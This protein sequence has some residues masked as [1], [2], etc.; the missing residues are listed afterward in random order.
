MSDPPLISQVLFLIPKNPPPTL[1]ATFSRAFREFVSACLQRDPL[2]RPTAKEL[3]KHRFV[4]SAKRTSSLVE[5]IERLQKWKKEGGERED[6]GD[7]SGSSDGEYVYALASS[8]DRRSVPPGNDDLWDF[9]TVRNVHARPGTLKKTQAA[10][11]SGQA[12]PFPPPPMVSTHPP[13]PA[14]VTSRDYADVYADSSAAF[15]TVRGSASVTQATAALPRSTT[16]KSLA[17]VDSGH[18]AL[19]DPSFEYYREHNGAGSNGAV[20]EDEESGSIL[21]T[22]LLP[23]LDSVR[24]PLVRAVADALNQI[25]NRLT[26]VEARNAILK[27]RRAIQEAEQEVPGL[28]N[29]FI[30]EVV[31]SV[32]PEPEEI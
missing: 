17:S 11:A 25:H 15:D 4:K 10:A 19:R 6:A 21:D 27:L 12:L 22:V 32:E 28:M 5:L 8:T 26:N 13:T 9:G 29:V 30:S 24:L 23:V 7:G 14:G 1:D 20:H 31:D 16:Q 2:L 3:L 18:D